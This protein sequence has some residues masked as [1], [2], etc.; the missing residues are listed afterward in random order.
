MFRIP[1]ISAALLAASLFFAPALMR[2]EDDKPAT[3]K[4]ADKTADKVAEKAPPAEVTT[5]G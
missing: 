5:Q 4:A 3:D 2:A 1:R